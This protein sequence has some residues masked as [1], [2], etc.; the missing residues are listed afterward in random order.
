[1]ALDNFK[2]FRDIAN[3][4]SFSK[5]ASQNGI[6]Q[7]AV[8][9]H[10][11]EVERRLGVSLLDRSTRPLSLTPAGRLYAELCRDVLR[12]NAQFEAALDALEARAQGEV[13]VASIYSIGISEMAGLREAFAAQHPEV[14]LHVDYLRPDKVVEA[15]LED[16]A[17]L[18]LISYPVPTKELAVIPWRQEQMAVAAP[19]SHALAQRKVLRPEDLSGVDYVAFDTDLAI[20]RE[21]DRFFRERTV[22]VN[23]TMQFDNIQMVKEAVAL[24]SGVSILP[25]RTM[26]AEI[27]QGRLVSVKLY[28]P[29]LFRPIGVIHLRRKA[30]NRAAQEFLKLLRA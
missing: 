16:Q 8:S 4:K 2:L 25:A 27:E 1:M 26:Q 13:R 3:M 11:Q 22:E 17:D 15:V 7:S 6:S 30:F 10:V 12:R 21:L 9:Q 19:P 14:Q 5:A 29:G 18:G 28:A 20:R 24:G 23:I